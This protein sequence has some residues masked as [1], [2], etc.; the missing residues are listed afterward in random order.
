MSS[1]KKER[2]EGGEGDLRGIRSPSRRGGKPAAV[3]Y[4]R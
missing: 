3:A 1:E 4:V 2:S